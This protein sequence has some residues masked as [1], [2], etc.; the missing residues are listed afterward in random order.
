MSDLNQ[1]L[2]KK[3]THKHD[4]EMSQVIL[5]FNQHKRVG[6]KSA[7]KNCQLLNRN[8][9]VKVKRK[10]MVEKGSKRYS[11]YN[12]SSTISAGFERRSSKNHSS[13]SLK[14]LIVKP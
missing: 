4:S 11:A 7:L 2:L 12:S 14:D 6:Q 1:D 9:S 8:I 10:S 13:S 5:S 3:L